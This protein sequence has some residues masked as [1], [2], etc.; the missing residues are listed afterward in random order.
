[1]QHCTTVKLSKLLTSFAISPFISG[2]TRACVGISTVS[3]CCS[4]LAGV[5]ITIIV[6]WNF[7]LF[8][9]LFYD[10]KCTPLLREFE[11]LCRQAG[12]TSNILLSSALQTTK[13]SP[14]V[15]THARKVS[16]LEVIDSYHWTTNAVESLVI[17]YTNFIAIAGL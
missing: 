14:G 8:D 1:M 5:R 10:T 16:R 3:T 6:I 4:I 2:N 9:W 17:V 13:P 12:R 11:Q 15:Q 7:N